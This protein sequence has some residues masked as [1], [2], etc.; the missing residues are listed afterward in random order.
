MIKLHRDNP[1]CFLFNKSIAII[2]LFYDNNKARSHGSV[3]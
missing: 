3:V 1:L 2:C